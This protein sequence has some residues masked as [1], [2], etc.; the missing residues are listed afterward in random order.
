[1]SKSSKLTV[2]KL[3]VCA[4]MIALGTVLS[5]VK[6]FHFPT[7][8]SITM[9]S[10]LI[11]CLPAYWFGLKEGLI[12]GVAYGILQLIIDPYILYPT[13]VIVDY[14]LAFGAMGLAG[15]FANKKNGLIPGYLIG[16]TGRF[17]FAV[18]SGAVFFGEYAW[19]GWNA[20]TYS[21]V[22]NAIY[23]Y[24]EGIITVIILLIKPVRNAIEMSA[25]KLINKE[26]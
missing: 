26:Q 19:E 5:N 25:K 6:V 13:Q 21:I 15:V 22:Y 11:I 8:G 10:M 17:V 3:A 20:W 18:I 9:F 16:I 7:G 4:V 24:A 14:I 12:T 1:M 2:Q 23:I